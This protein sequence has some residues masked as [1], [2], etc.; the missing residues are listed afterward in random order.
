[1]NIRTKRFRVC[2]CPFGRCV[3]SRER[4]SNRILRNK[5]FRVCF[6]FWYLLLY[7]YSNLLLYRSG[8]APRLNR[9]DVY[10][11]AYGRVRLVTSRAH[12]K[13]LS[14]YC[15]CYSQSVNYAVVGRRDFTAV[16]YFTLETL[17][18]WPVRARNFVPPPGE[19]NILNL[20]SRTTLF[21]FLVLFRGFVLRYFCVLTSFSKPVS[22]GHIQPII[23]IINKSISKSLYFLFIYIKTIT[24]Q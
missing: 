18:E 2:V 13:G 5:L 19:V 7:C 1:M 9:T 15:D 21:R 12:L 24:F 22:Q 16:A 3:P 23:L 6:F 8:T 14:A 17:E 20:I 10:R 4:Y 11:N